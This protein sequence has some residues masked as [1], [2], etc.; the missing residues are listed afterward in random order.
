MDSI[1]QFL[2]D[3]LGE[4][5]VGQ[6]SDVGDQADDAPSP[7]ATPNAAWD[8]RHGDV[9]SVLREFEDNTFD[10]VL[11][12]PPYGLSFMGKRWDYDVPSTELWAEVLRVCKPGAPL[13]AFFGT[14]T[15][16]RGVVRIEDAGW[17]IR[18]MLSWLY[19]SGFP[20]SLDVSKALDKSGGTDAATFKAELAEVV[21]RS[22]LSRKALDEACGFTMRFDTPYSADPIGWGVSLP[23]PE[24]WQK[25]A[26]V[27]RLDASRWQSLLDRVWRGRAGAEIDG[28]DCRAFG[29]CYERTAKGEP[30]TD[31]A[32]TWNGYGTAL[33]PACEPAVLARK[34]LE[35]TVAENVAKWGCGALAIDACRIGFASEEDKASAFPGGA[36]TS[37]KVTGG[38]LGCGQ[39]EHER[40]DFEARR[41]DAGRWPANVLL[42][43]EA[44]AIL[45]RQSG[46]LTSG[47]KV[48]KTR[49]R[50]DKRD[51][52]FKEGGTCYGD[53]GGASRFFYCAKA[54]KKERGEGNNHPT[55]KPIALCEYLAKLILPPSSSTARI[56]VPFAGSGSEMIGAYRAGWGSILGIEREAE[57]VEIARKRLT[58]L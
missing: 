32:K 19:G 27:L 28:D 26:A 4:V 9:L 24:K 54:S 40:G 42:D 7:L 41:S 57:Y 18:D 48:P 20:K 21:K 14:R 5:E 35:G 3:M 39:R 23:S 49:T 38:G 58:D 56:L 46:T 45:D 29:Q 33:K 10:G 44:A 50:D 55:V 13:V 17:E 34:P 36:L 15:Y 25:I 6:C 16:H 51:W 12:D 31:L 2:A 8:V 22:G 1:E 53:L 47:T 11:C 30:V 37:R 43:E 52:R